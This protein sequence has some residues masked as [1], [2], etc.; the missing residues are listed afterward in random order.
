MAAVREDPVDE[1]ILP[2]HGTRWAEP[3]VLW[4]GLEW[5]LKA[6]KM[7]ASAAAVSITQ[8]HV[9]TLVVIL[10]AACVARHARPIDAIIGATRSSQTVGNCRATSYWRTRGPKVQERRYVQLTRL[11]WLLQTFARLQTMIC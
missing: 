5:W 8:Q 7:V 11:A 6:T 4:D 1:V 3:L 10:L 2:A 9:V